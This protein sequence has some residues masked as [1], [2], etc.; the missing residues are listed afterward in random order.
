M[1]RD[2]RHEL[3]RQGER[4]AL[5]HLRRLGYELVAHNH[6]TR[7]GELDLVVCDGRTLVFAEVKTRRSSRGAPP[8]EALDERKRRQ[9]R[10]MASA[11]L[12]DVPAR[13]RV[14]D[15]RFDAIAVELDGTGGLVRLDHLEA[16]F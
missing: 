15:V 8:W 13:P 11:F 14:R 2:P 4:L 5:E 1:S 10:R 6:R 12:H 3:G 7:F 16:A 9:V